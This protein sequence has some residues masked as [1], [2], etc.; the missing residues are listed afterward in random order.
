MLVP[1]VLSYY[2]TAVPYVVYASNGK[3]SYIV[4]LYI[5]YRRAKQNM[6]TERVA[7]KYRVVPRAQ[8]RCIVQLYRDGIIGSYE[9]IVQLYIVTMVQQ[10]I[11][12]CTESI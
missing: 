5:L 1:P 12:E 3:V 11:R 6:C 10:Y 9:A 7:V 8:Y 4:Q 2:T